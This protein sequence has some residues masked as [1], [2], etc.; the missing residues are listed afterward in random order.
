MY[1]NNRRQPLSG[2]HSLRIFDAFE[3][4]VLRDKASG[5]IH[6]ASRSEYPRRADQYRKFVVMLTRKY[7]VAYV[8]DIA[9]ADLNENSQPEQLEHDN[10]IAHRHARWASVGE[11]QRYIG[12]KFILRTIPIDS[13]NVT[14]GML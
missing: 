14:K 4:L 8:G 11:L 10:T 3:R 1:W 13:K 9:I 2:D 5:S 12:E 7:G 6:A